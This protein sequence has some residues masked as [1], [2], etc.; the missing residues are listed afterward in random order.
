MGKV[1]LP[2]SRFSGDTCT[3]PEVTRYHP[4]LGG[5]IFCFSFNLS[6]REKKRLTAVY[7]SLC[8]LRAGNWRALKTTQKILDAGG[9]NICCHLVGWAAVFSFFPFFFIF[10]AFFFFFK[11]YIIIL[12]LP[13]IKMNPPQ[14][15]SS[16]PFF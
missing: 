11:L 7:Q 10:F 3:A 12:V 2:R 14:V 6:S 1:L 9:P 16:V 8:P 13:N 5:K 15:G 4:C